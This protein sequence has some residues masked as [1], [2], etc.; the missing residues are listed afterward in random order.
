MSFVWTDASAEPSAA[1]EVHQL[2]EQNVWLRIRISTLESAIR[3]IHAAHQRELSQ[4]RAG[5]CERPTLRRR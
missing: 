4:K 3:H 5:R 1:T 2:R